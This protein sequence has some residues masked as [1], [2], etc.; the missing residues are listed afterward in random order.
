MSDVYL[1]ET[2]DRLGNEALQQ[3]DLNQA[4]EA[5][6]SAVNLAEE[7]G[8]HDRLVLSLRNLSAT[9]VGQGLVGDS[10]ELLSRT[11]EVST[12]KLGATHSQTIETQRDLA[13]VCRELGYLDKAEGL[14]KEVLAQESQS[15]EHNEL[16]ATLLSLAQLSSARE[17]PKQ[18]AGYYQ[19]IVDIRRETL[20][21][22]HPDLAQ[23]LLWLSTALHQ[24][25]QPEEA[26]APLEQA[27]QIMEEQFS[28][29]P[30]HLAQSLLAA[31]QLMVESQQLEPALGHQ[32]RALTILTDNLP[33]EDTKIWETRELIATTLAGM[34]K[35]GEAIELLEFCLRKN[36][37]QSPH[38]MGALHKNL[39]G[40]YLTLGDKDKAEKFYASA[41][42][43]LEESLGSEHPAFLATQEERIQLYHFNGRSKEALDIALRCISATENRFGPGHPN[44]AQTYASTAL[45]AH[46]AEEWS[47]ALE[48]MKA[49]EKIWS[50]LNPKPEDVLANCRTNIA[51]CLMRLERYEDAEK[52]LDLA[53][54]TAGPSLRPVI[55]NLRREL[56]SAEIS[57]VKHNEDSVHRS[58]TPNSEPVLAYQTETEH[59]ET[60]TSENLEP[61]P[62]R[63]SLP[64]VPLSVNKIFEL[65]VRNLSQKQNTSVKAFMV[66]L[67]CGGLRINSDIA[68]PTSSLIE[69]TLPSE[70]L[71]KETAVLA[72]VAWQKSLFGTSFLQGLAFQEL[73]QEQTQ[74][75]ETRVNEMSLS[76]RANS[77]Q[78][79]RLYRPFPIKLLFLD[80]ERWIESY[81]TDL[82]M[83]GIGTR[84]K[85]A[86]PES[87]KIRL[88]LEF[89][90][91]LPPVEVIAQVAWSSDGKNGVS[92]GLK[93]SSV[94]PIE[95]NAIKVY[96]DRCLEFSPD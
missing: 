50:S 42:E 23:A 16:E 60:P 59:V 31:A 43:S 73:S 81:A 18:A 13:H 32:K 47:T 6:R 62:E 85:E 90:F 8:A 52:S 35:I 77:R 93:F 58:E 57:K 15:T 30:L 12:E 72:E 95:A 37:N 54:E 69:I 53:A 63:R 19:Q 24:S 92:H 66:D 56:T 28:D 17:L 29:Q 20:N 41:A 76:Q 65:Q 96:I 94:G 36:T 51:T 14:L 49:A 61:T 46:H 70:I 25:G 26:Q 86:L 74:L 87:E 68:L 88:R 83:E 33:E 9:M 71:G 4:T 11:L 34:G 82:S 64:R 5:F 27:L 78:H 10:Y 67:S 89:E 91:E 21:D 39:A 1:W 2:Y 44:T 45:L 84:L 38:L 79:Y 3:R 22:K 55:S 7:L 48:L 80:Q 75:L 40:L